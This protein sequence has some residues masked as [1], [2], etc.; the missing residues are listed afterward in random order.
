MQASDETGFVLAHTAPDRAGLVPS[1]VLHL[2]REPLGVFAAADAVGARQP[3]WAFAWPGG[4]AL[5]KAILD[6]PGLVTGRCVLDIGAGSGIA[7]I[8]A[9]KAGAA[10]A[11]ANDTDPCACAAARLN[12]AAN[13]VPLDISDEDL[14]DAEL[15]AD[16]LIVGDLI[17]DPAVARRVKALLVRA[18]EQ[19]ALVLFGD[20]ATSPPPIDMTLLS[21][22]AAP[23]TPAL[24]TDYME[25]G[26][27]WRLT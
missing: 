13:D 24:E 1:I 10:A 7:A 27:V 18:G 25:S 15:Q 5:A 16:V 4:Q 11:T 21:S 6:A 12:A 3:Y 22:Y 26:C 14:L 19:G 20:R 9:L 2:A 8:A 17:Y 23:L